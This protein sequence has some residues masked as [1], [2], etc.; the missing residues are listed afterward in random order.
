MGIVVRVEH[1]YQSGNKH[2]STAFVT[3]RGVVGNNFL[4]IMGGS[5]GSD[6]A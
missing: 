4:C 2:K 1:I 3:T 6:S 5:V